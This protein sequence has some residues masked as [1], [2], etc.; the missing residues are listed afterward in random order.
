[1]I[2][3]S[4]RYGPLGNDEGLYNATTHNRIGTCMDGGVDISPPWGSDRPQR[5][6]NN[7][8]LVS[9]HR[10][11]DEVKNLVRLLV[12]QLTRDSGLPCGCSCSRSRLNV[13]YSVMRCTSTI[14]AVSD[15]R[16]QADNQYLQPRFIPNSTAPA[17][18]A[19]GRPAPP[20]AIQHKC[21]TDFKDQSFARPDRSDKITSVD[22]NK[23]PGG[24]GRELALRFLVEQPPHQ[25][26]VLRHL[27]M[28]YIWLG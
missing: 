2:P 18:H 21:V 25:I 16:F 14:A 22:Y 10:K 26:I 28:V 11:L 20:E 1:M 9:V 12:K 8:D 27:M 4:N 24:E 17:S 7:L 6:H 3:C 23:D 19:E 13:P 5:L 15:P